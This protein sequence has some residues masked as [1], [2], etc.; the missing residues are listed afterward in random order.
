[1]PRTS[2]FHP[3]QQQ[4]EPHKPHSGHSGNGSSGLQSRSSI[5]TSG[6]GSINATRENSNVTTSRAN[7]NISAITAIL[8]FKRR[9]PDQ[10][11]AEP[12]KEF[13]PLTKYTS[14]PDLAAMEEREI[15]PGRSSG[16]TVRVRTNAA[17]L[18]RRMSFPSLDLAEWRRELAHQGIV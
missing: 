3:S 13:K 12:K 6:S 4:E 17:L 10:A 2:I 9:H 18:G 14:C 7:S 16:Q 8:T 11:P 5:S 1:M 15:N